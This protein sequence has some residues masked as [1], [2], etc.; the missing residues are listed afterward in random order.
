MVKRVLSAI[1]I[2]LFLAAVSQAYQ[3][4]VK[5]ELVCMVN[6]RVMGVPQIPVEV[7]GKTY[8]GCCAGCVG[9]LKNDESVRYAVDPISGNRVDK[10]EA[11]IVAGP[12]GLALYFENPENAKKYLEKLKK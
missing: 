10:A 11:Y 4:F 1:F 5:P 2:V 3:G 12:Q 7:E 9:T 6:D 8:Y